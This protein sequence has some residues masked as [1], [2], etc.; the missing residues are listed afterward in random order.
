MD[1]RMQAYGNVGA[2]S[3]VNE[4]LQKVYIWMCG[5]LVLTGI[6]SW[7]VANTPSLVETFVLNRNMFTGLII[8]E[9]ILVMAMS[10]MAARVSTFVAGAMFVAYSALNGLTLSVIFLAYT[11]SSIGQVFFLTGGMFAGMSLYG[12]VTKK[13]LTSWGSFLFMALLG[14][15][16]AMVVN[17]F[18][19]SSTMSLV[20]S[21]AGVI[22]F[23]GLTAYDTQKLKQI[24][25]AS[26]E[27]A[28]SEKPAIYGA[29]TLYLDFINL[30][31]SL[32]NILGKR[33]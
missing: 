15:V 3:L 27:V 6:V 18:L 20:I 16:L 5:G 23:V 26:P 10:F 33:R 30:F 1:T 29:L 12:F 31:L 22:I 11:L 9:L 14:M 19:K 24:A 32:L 28:G 17:F 2:R 21:F 13:D 4:F 8:A 25:L 7:H